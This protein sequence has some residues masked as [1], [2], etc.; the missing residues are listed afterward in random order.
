MTATV[1]SDSP[2]QAASALRETAVRDEY[3]ELRGL[4]FHY[5]DWPSQRA[6]ARTL[7][8][9]H[10]YTGHARSWDHF[11]AGMTDRYRVVALDQRGHGETA[12]APADRYGTEEMV[13]DLRAFVTALGLQDYHLLGL[14]MGGIV[15][16]HY[17]GGSG[18]ATAVPAELSRFVIVDIGPELIASGS[19]RIQDGTRARD[20]FDTKDEAVAQQ[21]AANARAPD[22][23]LRHRMENNLMRLEDGRWTWRYDRALRDPRNLR[24]RDP[25]AG[26]AAIA[27]IRVP[28]LL[29]RGAESDLL[30]AEIAQRMVTTLKDGHFAE[31]AGSGHSVP[32][33][34]PEG[35]AHAARSFLHG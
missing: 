10:G 32:L 19:A 30:S 2:A 31:V 6:D 25:V 21:R 7:V 27:G 22:A 33:D 11:A 35:F 14:S 18:A 16:F 5:R 20:V 24:L 8:L 34:A 12:W 9:L 29:I 1:Q 4:R 28:T 3:V 17:A 15:G 13:A 26:W 23:H